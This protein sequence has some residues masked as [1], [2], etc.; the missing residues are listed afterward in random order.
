MSTTK[1][2]LK[3]KPLC[4]VT[5]KLPKGIAVGAKEVALL[6]EFNNWSPATHI[7]EGSK[8]GSFKTTIDLETGKSYEYRY[9]IDGAKWV[10]DDAPDS[11]T[12]SGIGEELNSVLSL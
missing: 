6:G 5:F 10:N 11:L 1:K 3:S 8:D 4:K 7:L 2:Y 9:L 12:A